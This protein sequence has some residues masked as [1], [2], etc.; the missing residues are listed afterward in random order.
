MN[1]I[2]ATFFA[3]LFFLSISLI[4]GCDQDKS[5]TLPDT[6]DI[7][8]SLKFTLEDA[9]KG[10]TDA[11]LILAEVYSEGNGVQK[12]IDK[13]LVWYEIAGEAGDT[14]AQYNAGIINA[15]ELD[16]KYTGRY[17]KAVYWFKKLASNG[18]DDA[19]IQLSQILLEKFNNH[20][21]ALKWMK[22]AAITNYVAMNNLAVMYNDDTAPYYDE[23][24]AFTWFKK[25]AVKGAVNA[26]YVIGCYYA[27]GKL[28]VKDNYEAYKWIK[29][30]IKNSDS[31]SNIQVLEKRK[32]KLKKIQ[33]LLTSTQVN[34]IKKEFGYI[35]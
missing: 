9:L 25:A 3:L 12:N 1:L 29:K 10:D 24:K 16:D 22:D 34:K 32:L 21:A 23:Q 8:V 17:T 14:G 2:K 6:S 31:K 4:T 15:Y 33:E 18:D 27:D 26:M 20:S 13:A 30:S 11:Q 35:N 28:V 7:P 19:K 5:L